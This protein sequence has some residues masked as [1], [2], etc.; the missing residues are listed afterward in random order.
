[1]EYKNINF[2]EIKTIGNSQLECEKLVSYFMNNKLIQ[3]YY[4]QFIYCISSFPEIY[5]IGENAWNDLIE[6][7]KDNV[8]KDENLLDEKKVIQ[9]YEGKNK[10]LLNSFNSIKHLSQLY[11][12]DMIKIF[13]NKQNEDFEKKYEL[14]SVVDVSEMAKIIDNGADEQTNFPEII[15]KMKE[16]EEKS[17]EI[18]RISEMENEFKFDN[19]IFPKSLENLKIFIIDSMN[20]VMNLENYSPQYIIGLTNVLTLISDI[21][22]KNDFDPRKNDILNDLIE[23][24]KHPESFY[25]QSKNSK[26]AGKEVGDYFNKLFPEYFKLN[27]DKFLKS[28]EDIDYNQQE[29]I[30][31]N[32]GV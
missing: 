21:I 16:I 19:F 25:S 11:F 9:F 17:S 1:M 8:K 20:F 18:I 26:I 23:T 14:M 7:I 3:D 28:F 5:L 6:S 27:L 30:R 2:S 12:N 10:D 31:I 24:L 22:P 29:I 13:E 32:F 4:S 15:Y